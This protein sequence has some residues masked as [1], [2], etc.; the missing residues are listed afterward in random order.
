MSRGFQRVKRCTIFH[1]KRVMLS[2]GFCLFWNL[3]LLPHLLVGKKKKRNLLVDVVA[4]LVSISSAC[5]CRDTFGWYTVLFWL[6]L[7]N[8]RTNEAFSCLILLSSSDRNVSVSRDQE[9]ENKNRNGWLVGFYSNL[10]NG[11]FPLLPIP[12]LVVVR[13]LTSS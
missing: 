6:G 11:K 9:L 13:I 8:T 5:C 4:T 2:V 10:M 3:G 7:L 12:T 1:S